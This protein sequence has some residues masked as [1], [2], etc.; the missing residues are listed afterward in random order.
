MHLSSVVLPTP[1]RPIRHSHAPSGTRSRLLP[2]D[3]AAA[4]ELVERC[5]LRALGLP[6]SPRYTSIT[7][8][9]SCICIHAAL[10]QHRPSC[11][12]V[13]VR[14]IDRTNSMSCSTTTTECS[15]ASDS[16][17]SA[18]V[19][20]SCGVMPA[21]GSSTSSTRGSCMSS[22]PISSHCFWPWERTPARRALILRA[23][24]SR[25]VSS[26]RSPWPRRSVLQ[27]ACARPL[28]ARP[29]ELQV[30]EHRAVLEYASASG[31]CGRCRASAISGS[32]RFK[33]SDA[34]AER[35]RPAS[36]RVLPVI[37]SIIVVL[38]APFGPMM[39]RSSPTS[40]YELQ[41]VQRA[42]PVEAH[43]DLFDI[44]EHA[45]R[46]IAAG[47]GR[48][49]VGL[50]A[51]GPPTPPWPRPRRM[52]RVARRVP[53]S[54]ACAASGP[55]GEARP[56]PRKSDGHE[57]EQRAEH[58]QP[59]L[60]QYGRERRLRVIHEHGTERRAVQR[61]APADRDPDRRA[62]SSSAAGIPSG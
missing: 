46:G 33:Q 53:A 17:S 11:S 54:Q 25:N 61:A 32:V 28:V 26:I 6:R 10:G 9:S 40:M 8:G 14:A 38:P 7:L 59:R 34:A 13:T 57:H 41:I 48:S 43:G 27:R 22:M 23:R 12:T 21:T 60:G 37:T 19:S 52:R 15:P 16:S 56:A 36:G 55:R 50:H 30:L 29:R 44:Q 18:V 24:S 47:V 31:T 49:L 20:T 62:R 35:T 42:E 58:E 1:L 5:D 4:V 2:E 45:V 39:Q 51:P 3:V